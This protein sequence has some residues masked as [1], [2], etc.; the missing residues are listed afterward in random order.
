MDAFTPIGQNKRLSTP[1]DYQLPTLIILFIIKVK[2]INDCTNIQSFKE[3]IDQLE[4]KQ[5]VINQKKRSSFANA[6]STQNTYDYLKSK[7][8]ITIRL[9]TLYLYNLKKI[10][11]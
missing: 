4:C 11:E 9:N 10:S 1:A 3:A 7:H 5:T 6:S 2:K 8:K